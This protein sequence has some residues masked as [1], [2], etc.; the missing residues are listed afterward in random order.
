MSVWE[1]TCYTLAIG[2][3]C[4]ILIY[5]VGW[6]FIKEQKASKNIETQNAFTILIA[7]RN[8]EAQIA[9][10]LNAILV[11]TYP[12]HLFEIIVLNDHSTDATAQEVLRIKALNPDLNVQLINAQEAGF[13]GKKNAI[14]HGV[15][16]A[17][18]PYIILTDA[19]CT[20]GKDWLQAIDGFLQT[21]KSQFIYA[22]V[23][24]TS[25]NLFESFQSLEF[26]GLVGIG[27]AAIRLKNPNMCS[28]ANLIFSKE[29]FTKVGG[30]LDNVHMASG[31][32]EF[33]LHK[34]FKQYPNEVHFLKDKRSI[35]YTSPNASVD[36]LTQ[37]RRR[38][39]SKST[40]YENR[41]ITAILVGAYFFNASIFFNVLAGI[42]LP[43][44]AGVGLNQLLIKM[45]AEGLLLG[46]ILAFFGTRRLLLLVPLVQPFHILY[47]IIIG[48]WANI[49][50]YT[51][52]ERELK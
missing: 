38:W 3:A 37:Q 14:T 15:S 7:A 6:V 1:I 11:Q 30:Y 10:C 47:V 43:G 12:K 36:Q 42:W 27:G 18:S 9:A 4:L 25:S 21:K 19:D 31:D 17:K 44:F 34:V 2:Y 33:L 16:V 23:Y 24:F 29:S 49:Q 32:D 39:V 45:T 41:Y 20:R 8:E 46:S 51:W 50:T 22:P 5:F 52:K 48:V 40:K 28:A 26:A 35:V 13:T